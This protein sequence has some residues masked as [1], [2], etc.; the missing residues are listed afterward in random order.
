MVLRNSIILVLVVAAAMYCQEQ[1]EKCGTFR[2]VRLLTQAKKSHVE[3][4]VIA[5]PIL[6]KN[7]LTRNNRIRI[8]YDTSGINTPAMVDNSGI[9]IPNSYQRFIDTLSVILDSVWNVEINTFGFNEPPADDNRGGGNE[10]DF[11]VE[12]LSGGLFGETI[13]ETDLPVGPTKTNQQYA[14]YIRID[15]DFGIGFRTKGVS[16][17]LA[18]TAHEFYHAIQVGGSGV[19]EDDHFYFYE[20]CAEAMENT[21]F[22]NAKDYIFDVKTYFTNISS[23]PLFVLRSQTNYAGYERAIWGMFLMKKYGTSIMKDIWEE[24]K[25]QRPVPALND[26]LNRR[27]TSIQR[28]FADFSFWNFFTALRADS[29]RYYSDA[30]ILPPVALTRTFVA[31]SSTQDI[32]VISK[33]F[34]SNYYKV[35]VSSDS[36]FFIVSNTNYNDLINDGQKTLTSRISFTSTASLGYPLV[37]NSIYAMF[38]AVEPQEWSY[39]PV[40]IKSLSSC[41][42]NPFKPSTSSLLISLEGIGAVNDATLTILSLN[43]FDL[44]YS[45]N[46]QYT[47]FSGTQYA[48]WKGRDNKGEIVPSGIYLYIL[49]KGSTIIKGKFAVIR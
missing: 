10:F 34:V 29:V 14:T 15:N 27:S 38:T 3:L 22:K 46:A 37:A 39:I 2:H 31:N 35:S 7:L 11:Y 30:K 32:S 49:S 40:G 25:R 28:E 9:R 18:T 1:T 47:V 13:I 45:N 16:A 12:E 6:Q 33:S 36:A 41:F 5:R 48:E 4:P 20:I 43:N 23:I 42:P 19:W 8:H 24:I 26:A 44:V 21:V 17:I